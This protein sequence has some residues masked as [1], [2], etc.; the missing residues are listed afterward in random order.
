MLATL[1]L[2]RCR[3]TNTARERGLGGADGTQ[4]SPSWFA[5]TLGSPTYAKAIGQG[6][7]AAQLQHYS[8]DLTACDMTDA[9]AKRFVDALSANVALSQLQLQGNFEVSQAMRA[10]IEEQLMPEAREQRIQE[11]LQREE[12]ERGGRGGRGE[13]GEAFGAGSLLLADRPPR[14]Q[15][16]EASKRFHVPISACRLGRHGRHQM[17]RNRRSACSRGRTPFGATPAPRDIAR[18]RAAGSAA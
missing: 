14:Q 3:T 17:Q 10:A 4:C 12:G 13:K 11:K 18:A 1:D 16:V 7:T 2:W 8:T 5:Y 9:G 15:V 6:C